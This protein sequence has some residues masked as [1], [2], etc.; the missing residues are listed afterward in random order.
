MAVV[1]YFIFALGS[2]FVLVDPIGCIPVLFALTPYNGRAERIRMVVIACLTGT[3]VLLFFALF[4][5]RLFR[6]LG[7]SLPAVQIA[8]SFVLFLVAYDMLRAQRSGVK[9]TS[10]EVD[11]GIRKT[12]VAITPLA[13]PMLAGPGS[14]ANVILLHSRADSPE[15]FGALCGAIVAVFACSFLVLGGAAFAFDRIGQTPVKILTRLMGLIVAAVAAQF[16][17]NGLSDVLGG[18]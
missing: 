7:V 6:L 17:L 11:E 18:G 3:I 16:L 13:V 12:D 14:I 10:E 4:G 1:D 15:H 2:L 8:G 5:V 9:E